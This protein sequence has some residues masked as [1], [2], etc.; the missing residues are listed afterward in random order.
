M[1]DPSAIRTILKD[2]HVGPQSLLVV[3]SAF[4]GLSRQG[5]QAE[6]VI[7][8]L[9]DHVGDGGLFMPTMTWRT[10]TPEAPHWDEMRTPSHTGVMTEIFRTRYATARSIHPTHSVA[11]Y[12]K[13]AALILSRHQ[14]G[15]TPV[16]E[17]SP[18]ALMQNYDTHIL[19]VG[20]GL[21]CCTAIHMPEEILAEDVYV[22]PPETAFEYPCTDRKGE[23]HQVRARRHRRLARDFPKFAKGLIDR[24]TMTEGQISGCPW[25]LVSLAALL[26]DVYA[27]LLQD[28]RATLERN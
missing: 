1:S 21:E 24:R 8:A 28:D 10:V 23:V 4:A 11:G 22:Q 19:M 13:D 16:S 17:T 18:Y 9:L 2:G 14:V 25:R 27:E 3:H 6:A 15:D 7:E 20:V 5:F 26:R 12:G